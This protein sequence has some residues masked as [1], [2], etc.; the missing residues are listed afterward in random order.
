[1]TD[2]LT[3]ERS[4]FNKVQSPVIHRSGRGWHRYTGKS[5]MAAASMGGG[6]LA[7]RYIL[8]LAVASLSNIQKR[9]AYS[10]T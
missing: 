10:T 7:F 3:L 4:F 9:M 5:E 2:P 6:H 8:R 1:M